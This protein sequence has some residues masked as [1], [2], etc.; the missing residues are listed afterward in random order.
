[1]KLWFALVAGLVAAPAAAQN[2]SMQRK[3]ARPPADVVFRLLIPLATSG[4]PAAFKGQTLTYTRTGTPSCIGSDGVLS[5]LSANTACT[6]SGALLIEPAATNLNQRSEEL[7]NAYW[8][9][10]GATTVTA[11]GAAFIDGVTSMDLITPSCSGCVVLRNTSNSGAGPWTLSA[12]VRSASSTALETIGVNC[13]NFGTPTNCACLRSDGGSCTTGTNSGL[14]YGYGTFG[15]TPVRLSVSVSCTASENNI[16]PNLIGGR[17]ATSTA[18][19]YFGGVQL[20]AGAVATSYVKTTSATATRGAVTLTVPT[21]SSWPKGAGAIRATVTQSFGA[22]STSRYIFDSRSAAAGVGGVALFIDSSGQANC[23]TYD[24][25]D[26]RTA[27]TGTLT[28][29]GTTTTIR[30]EWDGARVAVSVSSTV[31]PTA[32]AL[33]IPTGHATTAY[34]GSDNAGA[35]Q[36]LGTISDLCVSS[37]VTGCPR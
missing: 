14:C 4:T 8:T 32:S 12:W 23:S 37:R 24:G 34:V 16:Q 21:S 26:T 11:D 33:G 27:Q 10:A 7:D 9:K 19:G 17:F 1:M 15:T 25:T 6:T 20:E 2:F 36:F 13:A 22:T 28:T 35:N 29:I 5:S 18:T 31:V 3:T 30:C